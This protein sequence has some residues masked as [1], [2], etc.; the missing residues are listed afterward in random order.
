[1]FVVRNIETGLF[2]AKNKGA[3]AP[4]LKRAQVFKSESTATTSCGDKT[5]KKEFEQF[6]DAGGRYFEYK[7]RKFDY[8]MGNLEI[9]PLKNLL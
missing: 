2:W 7:G 9:V 8:D 3:N 4:L 5:Y 6:L 1:M